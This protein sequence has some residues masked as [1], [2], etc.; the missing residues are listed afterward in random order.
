MMI[1]WRTRDRSSVNKEVAV[2]LW[3]GP[4]VR[5]LS[6]KMSSNEGARGAMT[7]QYAC[8]TRS[9]LHRLRHSSCTMKTRRAAP[10]AP[11]PCF[12]L[13]LSNLSI[14][15]ENL[16]WTSAPPFT[17]FVVLLWLRHH[18]Q[19]HLHRESG[20]S[21]MSFINKWRERKNTQRQ[22]PYSFHFS[23]EPQISFTI[24]MFVVI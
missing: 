20:T 21:S 17:W 1:V 5:H 23:K 6:P 11:T 12:F 22:S 4:L 19:Q 13:S 14:E 3:R 16:L 8:Q 9:T 2:W 7:Y 18:L 15:W 24:L 10:A